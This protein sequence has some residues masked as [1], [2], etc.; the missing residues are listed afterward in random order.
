MEI[1]KPS[2]DVL[3]KESTDSG[4]TCATCPHW[5]KRRDMSK[6][7]SVVGDCRA[8]PP[9]VFLIPFHDAL[10]GQGIAERS[11]F[12]LVAVTCWCGEHPARKAEVGARTV[13][14]TLKMLGDSPPEIFNSLFR[15]INPQAH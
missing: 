11:I 10:R 13:A 6:A 5:F 7:D 9:T 2:N 12:P 4:P 14:L 15:S 8:K 1:V 3:G